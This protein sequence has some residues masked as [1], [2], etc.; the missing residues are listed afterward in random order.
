MQISSV[1]QNNI[2]NGN[3]TSNNATVNTVLNNLSY[4]KKCQQLLPTAKQLCFAVANVR[5]ARNKT[6][7]IID[8]VMGNKIDLCVL[9]E[10]WL[11]D[12][13]SVSISS[14]SPPGYLFHNCPR[15]SQRIGGGIGL[16]HR[17]N[18]QTSRTDS[19]EKRSFEYCEWNIM[20]LSRPLKIIGIYRPPYSEAHP[21]SANVFFEEFSAYLENIVMYPEVL[22]ISGDFNFHLDSHTDSDADKFSDLLET[23]GLI[24]HVTTHTHSS[25]HILDLVVT[26]SCYD[27]LLQIPRTTFFI[28]DHCFIEIAMAFPPRLELSIK[29]ICFRQYK[30]IDIETFKNN[31]LDSEL[32]HYPSTDLLNLAK[33]YDK[34]LTDIL[35]RNAPLLHKTVIVKP[36]F[37]WFNPELKDLKA[38]RRKLEKKVLRIQRKSDKD[39]YRE[40]YNKYTKLLHDCKHLYYT[41]QI[42]QCAGDSRKLFQVVTSLCNKKQECPLP[43]HNDS[44]TLANEF[45]DIFF[46]R[47]I[48]LLRE[49]I[50]RIHMV[51]PEINCYPP[52][53]QLHSFSTVTESDVRTVIMSSSSASCKLDPIPTWLLKLCIDEPLPVTTEI[54]SLSIRGGRVPADWKCALVKKTGP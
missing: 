9:T 39:A 30:K 3:N 5:S 6:D 8:H 37:P 22:L 42:N 13:D 35:E 17:D 48:D 15:P 19:G 2:N 40:I 7:L 16:M 44:E 25:G 33:T 46:C 23:F 54:V 36:M 14:L 51:P 12:E 31:I 26:R 43:P 34:V 1:E 20:N 45:G 52:E 4:V 41:E 24:Q 47:K 32:H 38:K 29:E 53:I 10:T 28:S 21:V 49:E 11:K 27:F 18:L 50:D